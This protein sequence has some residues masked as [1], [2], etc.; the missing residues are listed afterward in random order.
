MSNATVVSTATVQ[1]IKPRE[2]IRLGVFNG[3]NSGFAVNWYGELKV[4]G[5]EQN[6][7][8]LVCLDCMSD[9]GNAMKGDSKLAASVGKANKDGERKFKI[10]GSTDK[11]RTTPAM[12]V[13]GCMQSL[14]KIRKEKLFNDSLG[15]GRFANWIE[16]LPYNTVEYLK[17]VKERT[18]KIDWKPEGE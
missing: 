4:W 12:T 7:A 3:Q 13:V 10:S 6:I 1:P 8:H 15:K 14:E 18:D 5:V 17:N 9:L 16:Y 2:V 11:Q